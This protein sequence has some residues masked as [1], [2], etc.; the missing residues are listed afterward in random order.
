MERSRSGTRSRHSEDSDLEAV[1]AAEME[2]YLVDE[3]N[4]W[5]E[6]RP[7]GGRAQRKKNASDS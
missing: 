5:L 4:T 3:R 7:P 1:E 2:D 6:E